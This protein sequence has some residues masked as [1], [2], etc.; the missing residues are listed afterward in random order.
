MPAGAQ[1]NGCTHTQREGVTVVWCEQK[2]ER[3]S[4][5]NESL[6][7]LCLNVKT[8]HLVMQA[9]EHLNAFTRAPPNHTFTLLEA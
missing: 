6:F 2:K 9:A 1:N 5:T 4:L 8:F 7:C 3:K